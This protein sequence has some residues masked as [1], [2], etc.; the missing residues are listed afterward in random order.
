[1]YSFYLLAPFNIFLPGII[2]IIRFR[3]I[4]SIYYPFLYCLWVGCFNEALSHF[5]ILNG[6]YTL[7]NNNIYVLLESFLLVWLFRELGVIRQKW[8]FPG[9]LF[10]LAG[11]WVAENFIFG[12]IT[13]YSRFFRIFYS[14]VLVFLS[15]NTINKLLFSRRRLLSDATFLLCLSF[16]IYFTYKAL[17]CSF[18]LSKALERSTFLLNV[19]HIM[20]YVNFITNLL[21]ALVVLWMPGKPRYLQPS[22]SPLA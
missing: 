12:S 15:I 21:Y 13:L 19:F 10:V 5:L 18:I 3:S 20:S 1:M 14:F 6:H 17:A 8:Q 2:A 11:F 9:L 7:V 22:L 4:H 16:I